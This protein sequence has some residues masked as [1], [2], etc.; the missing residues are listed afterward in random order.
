MTAISEVVYVPR[1]FRG[2][3]TTSILVLQET[4]RDRAAVAVWFGEI[5]RR[6]HSV[7]RAR[8]RYLEKIHG[9]LTFNAIDLTASRVFESRRPAEKPLCRF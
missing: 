4:E 5:C 3:G 6:N 1:L 7:K 9:V 8:R 2:L